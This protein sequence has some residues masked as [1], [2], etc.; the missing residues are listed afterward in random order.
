[1]T[2]KSVVFT[3]LDDT[4][5][6]T[7]RKQE[8]KNLDSFL[9]GSI[10]S[11]GNPSGYLNKV[12]QNFFNHLKSMG[13]I[14]PVT[15]RVTNALD[16][17]IIFEKGGDAIWYHGAII[18]YNSKI[19]DEWY[20]RSVNIL[21]EARVSFEKMI[22]LLE[23]RN[24][25]NYFKISSSKYEDLDSQQLQVLIRNNDN[26]ILNKDLVTDLLKDLTNDDL[27]CHKQRNYIT[28]LPKGIS[29]R[30]AVNYLIKKE[31]FDLTIGCGDSDV[32]LGFMSLC[33]YAVIPKKSLLLETMNEEN[34]YE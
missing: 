6:S 33:D 32:D 18:R 8:S 23:K 7:L 12:Q 9:L 19:D 14:I 27:Y 21:K 29:K 17:A 26:S 11:K 24:L 4:I 15:A 34:K 3:D 30:E 31:D 22:E 16:R 25:D 13:K 1:M 20:E 5:F 28:F 2:N 10:D